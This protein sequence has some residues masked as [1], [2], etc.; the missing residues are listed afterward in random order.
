MVRRCSRAMGHY[1]KITMIIR[2][3]EANE[4][5]TRISMICE[6]IYSSRRHCCPN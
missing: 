4:W 5:I 2:A 3:C 6:I 1:H